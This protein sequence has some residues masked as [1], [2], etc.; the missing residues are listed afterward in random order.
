MP[1][2]PGINTDWKNPETK[3]KTKSHGFPPHYQLHHHHHQYF[4][5]GL[6]NEVIA[7]STQV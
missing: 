1:V 4:K 7:T 3:K 2:L 6:N 5:N